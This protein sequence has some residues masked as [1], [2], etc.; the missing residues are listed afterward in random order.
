M[1]EKVHYQ[2]VLQLQ[3]ADTAGEKNEVECGATDLK[4]LRDDRDDKDDLHRMLV[5]LSEQV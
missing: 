3:Q 1:S 2:E 5:R 4:A